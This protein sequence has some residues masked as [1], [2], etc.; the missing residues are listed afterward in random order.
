MA[1]LDNGLQELRNERRRLQ[2][3][4]EKLDSVISVLEKLIGRNSPAPVR[5]AGADV[6]ASFLQP[7]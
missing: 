7:H 4:V 3:Q 5:D 1:Y 6:D 2:S